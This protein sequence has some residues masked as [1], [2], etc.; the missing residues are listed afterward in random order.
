MIWFHEL[1]HLTTCN[2]GVRYLYQL[3]HHI[4]EDASPPPD[5]ILGVWAPTPI[6]TLT[7]PGTALKTASLNKAAHC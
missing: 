2:R 3:V 7:V 6:L 4:F 5:D 1:S